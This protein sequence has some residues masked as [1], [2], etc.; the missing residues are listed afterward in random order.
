[1]FRTSLELIA[2]LASLLL[3]A[4]GGVAQVMQPP[5]KPQNNTFNSTFSFTDAELRRWNLSKIAAANIEA[6]VRFER[7]NWATG[8]VHADPFYQVPSSAA[9]AA[10]GD[11]I[12]VENFTDT[13]YYTLPPSV[14]LSRFIYQ[15]ENFNGTAV[16]ASAFVLWPW[17][18]RSFPSVK[19]VPVVAFGHGT[20]GLFGQSGPS[21]IRNLWYHYSAPFELATHGYAVVAPDYAGLGLDRDA[22]GKLIPHQYAA[23]PAAAN[24]L[25]Y[26]V[27]AARK[28]WPKRLSEEF[29]TMGHSQGGGAAWAGAVRQAHKPVKGYLGTVAASP[30]TSVINVASNAGPS[31]MDI[32]PVGAAVGAGSIFPAFKLEDWL[33]AAGAL[34]TNLLRAVQGGQSAITE[35]MSL[36]GLNTLSNWTQTWSGKAFDKLTSVRGKEISGPMLVLQG[37]AD[38]TV[39]STTTTTAVNELCS[40]HK[41]TQLQYATFH[42]VSHLPVLFASE[43]IW[44]DWISDRFNRVKVRKTCSRHLYEPLLDSAVYQF[45]IGYFLEYPRY[46][47]EIA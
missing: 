7:T 11:I 21:H 24:D 33:T 4:A 27:E 34:R 19:G 30:L 10:P 8:S 41:G 6:A 39:N 25:F 47:Y 20:S 43:S 42:N 37:T 23:N 18:P 12:K 9:K 45:E 32:L 31:I 26:A 36:G 13:S 40:A 15:S 16:P 14:A 29:I 28:A 38:T 1:M 46:P 22:N 44:L 3:F 5:A 35:I 2:M 17:L